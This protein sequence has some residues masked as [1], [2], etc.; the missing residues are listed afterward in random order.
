[1]TIGRKPA[2][3][4][5]GWGIVGAGDSRGTILGSLTSNV[6]ITQAGARCG[7]YDAGNATVGIAIFYATS[8]AIGALAQTFPT[9][10]AS[11]PMLDAY[12]GANYTVNPTVPIPWWANTIIAE[13]IRAQTNRIAH[14]QDNSGAIMHQ[15]FNIGTAF[16]TPYN[17]TQVDPQGVSS[18]W[19]ETTA[20]RAPSTP[21]NLAPA[22]DAITNSTTPTLGA[23]FR[24]PDETVGGYAIGQAD[25]MSAYQFE[26]WND[27][28]SR[29]IQSS[30]KLIATAAQK[31]ARRATWAVPTALTA[32][33]YEMRCIVYD[34]FGTPSPQARWKVTVNTGGAFMSPRLSTTVATNVTNQ[35]SP[36]WQ[37]QWTSSA[38]VSASSIQARVLNEDGTIA[39]SQGSFNYSIAPGSTGIFTF[40]DFGWSAL[41]SGKRYQI[42]FKGM[43]TLGG[44]SPWTRTPLFLVNGPPNVATNRSPASGQSFTTRPTLAATLT[45]PD[46]ASSA[47]TPDFRVRPVGNT[48]TGTL[49][50]A[51]YAGGNVWRAPTDA[52]SMPALG[53]FEWSVQITDPYGAASARSTWSAVNWVTAATVTITAPAAGTITTGTPTVTATVDRAVTSYRVRMLET[54]AVN[55]SYPVAY[56]SDVI[57]SGTI[58]HTIPAGRLR[59]GRGY[60]IELTVVTSDGLTTVVTRVVTVS[61][62]AQPALMGVVAAPQAAQF[63]SSADSTSWSTIRVAWTAPT[64]TAIPDA[65]F[66]GYLVRRKSVTT[67]G[68]ETVALLR[69]RGETVYVDRTPRSGEAYSY[70]PVALRLVNL[71]DWVESTPASAQAV[72]RLKYA[73]LSEITPNGLSLPLRAW[74]SRGD[75]P[76]R[77][78]DVVPTLGRKP[79]TFQGLMDYAVISGQFT[80]TDQPE[81]GA[82]VEDQLAVARELRKPDEDDL[83]RPVPKQLCYR[84][85][86]RRVLYVSVT[87]IGEEDEHSVRLAR[88]SLTLTENATR[89]SGATGGTP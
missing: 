83:G 7:R 37:G 71:L 64:T 69:T 31:S 41:T 29:R 62:P 38:G 75:A 67:G 87:D 44:D 73:T 9:F 81:V 63:E 12:S 59:N 21:S 16:P 40:G 86:K 32:A 76:V 57:A 55:G 28:G 65:E 3:N 1:M 48:G 23:D 33:R 82:V 22:P 43:D 39:R 85:P 72:V 80:I 27:A 15:R 88:L 74:Q 26:V 10:T 51:T 79:V 78:I 18:I 60:T 47:L 19:L 68:E 36:S 6:W 46:H 25:A 58:S 70:T 20:N 17:A 5:A 52:T 61:Y 53:N 2:G 84:D 11:T 54:V 50:P 4:D 30:G 34:Y 89:L 77:D 45:D 8:S 24:D 66:G 56:D 42:E 35:T 14:G 13:V 49:A